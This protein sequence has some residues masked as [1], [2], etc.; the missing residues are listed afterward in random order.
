M[1]TLLTAEQTITNGT[2]ATITLPTDVRLI[3]AARIRWRGVNDLESSSDVKTNTGSS[4]A[5]FPAKGVGT[6]NRH[7]YAA[8]LTI[9]NN[10][11]GATFGSGWSIGGS[12]VDS[13]YIAAGASGTLSVAGSIYTDLIGDTG[14][15]DS[16][17]GDHGDYSVSSR[18]ITLR[19]HST[20][21][22]SIHSEDPTVISGGATVIGPTSLEGDELSGWYDL[23]NV[24]GR[25]DIPLTHSVGGSGSVKIQL[26]AVYHTYAGTQQSM[27]LEM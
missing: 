4:S 14:S 27:L 17:S 18:S 16:T 20:S 5:T 11:A 24:Y 12:R 10:G 25:K 7:S 22:T 19:T 15:H 8:S 9:T 23:P 26:E 21:Y 6:F 1:P 13:K 3:L 2:V